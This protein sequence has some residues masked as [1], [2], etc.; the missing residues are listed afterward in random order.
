MNQIKRK[1]KQ[2]KES[3][4]VVAVAVLAAIAAMIFTI[5]TSNIAFIQDIQARNG[6]ALDLPIKTEECKHEVVNSPSCK[7]TE[8]APDNPGLCQDFIAS[9]QL[10]RNNSNTSLDTDIR[11]HKIS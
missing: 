10:T 11:K 5:G 9:S 3:D 2:N 6:H 8:N 4:V 1:T 7:D